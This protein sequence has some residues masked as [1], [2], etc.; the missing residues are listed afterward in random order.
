MKVNLNDLEYKPNQTLK[1]SFCEKIP[2]IESDKVTGE[3]EISLAPYGAEVQGKIEAKIILQCDRCLEDFEYLMTA[4]VKEKF[5]KTPSV[6]IEKNSKEI[7]L[8]DDDDFAQVL[9]DEKEID[10]SDLVYQ[11]IVLNMPF[12]R[13]CGSGCKGIGTYAPSFEENDVDPRLEIFKKLSEE[14]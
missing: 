5:I 8:K 10:I 3:I 14:K 11:T 13:V 1:I 9:N 7:E 4:D 12:K 2:D 6:D